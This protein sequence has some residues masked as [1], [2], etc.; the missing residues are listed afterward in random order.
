M[1]NNT[2]RQTYEPFDFGSFPLP[3][4]EADFTNGCGL[5]MVFVAPHEYRRG[6]GNIDDCP[7]ALPSHKCMMSK[8][9]FISDEP[10]KK[11]LFDTF[12]RE[13]YQ[14]DSDTEEYRGFVLGV[15]WYE[16]AEF[17]KW[18]SEKE[19]IFYRLPTEAEWEAAARKST[20]LDIDRMCDSHIREWCFDWYS[21]YSDLDQ[22]DPAGPAE[23]MFK[24]IRGGYL[25]N[26]GR[27]TAYPLDL[28]RRGALPPSYRHYPEDTNNDF[29]RHIIGFRVACGAFPEVTICPPLSRVSENVHQNNPS[30]LQAPDPEKPY[31]RKRYIFPTPP[32]NSPHEEII[33]TGFSPLFRN[34]HHSPALTVCPNGDLL[35]SIYSTYHEYDAESGL[36]GARLRAGCDEWE[37]PDVWLNPVG[38]ND[39][40]PNM[41]TDEDGTIYHFWGWQ[42]LDHSFPFQYVSSKDNGVTWSPVQFPFFKNKV[43]ELVR[44]PINSCIRAKDGTFYMAS[45]A[46]MV[47][48]SVLWR[49][50]DN[51]KTWENPSGRTAGRHTSFVELGDGT[52]L[53]MGG[54]N[55]MYEDSYY[56]P[57]SVSHDE[58]ETWTTIKTPF[59]MMFSGQRPCIIKLQSGRLF[60]CGDFQ[61][62]KNQKPADVK[63]SGSYAAW[64]D[65][66]GQHWHITQM[67]GAE[68]SKSKNKAEFGGQTTL[69][70]SVC[71]QAPNGMIHV[72]ASN[73]KHLLH[74]EFN[75]A[76]LLSHESTSPE[77]AALMQTH[78]TAYVSEIQQFTEY[79][80]DGSLRCKWSGGLADDGR[81]LME[82]EEVFY[83]PDGSVMSKGSYHLGRRVGEYVSYDREGYPTYRIDVAPGGAHILTTYWTGSEKLKTR[84]RFVNKDADGIAQTYGRKRGNVTAEYT[85]RG[86]KLIDSKDLQEEPPSP[87]G[88]IY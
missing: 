88:E 54:K 1:S 68:R 59:P 65:D 62:K 36:A 37:L 5:R 87:I 61:N 50:H 47:P 57:A 41:F 49:S 24:V 26:P 10:I 53:G 8:P 14:Q 46:P 79:Y 70:Y 13:R 16:A 9:Y 64:S 15:S 78:A 77:D 33:A 67:W 66:D 72:V 73:N 58:G 86:G 6:G 75:E 28:W 17:C 3:A 12:Y 76:W 52:L 40:A 44:Q 25:D 39:H 4:Q 43:S 23:G 80:E 55:S 21:V 82:G 20:E 63:E 69:G 11:E 18:L 22:T 51:M 38:V 83:Y 30:L 35:L 74:F 60:M 29:G 32:D 42:Q 7:D 48:S 84:A 27:Y 31:F 34:H 85:F 71:K 56:M 81:F 19:G 2:D 45:D